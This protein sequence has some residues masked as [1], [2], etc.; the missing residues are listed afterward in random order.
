MRHGGLCANAPVRL[1]LMKEGRTGMPERPGIMFYFSDWEP[2]TKLEDAT[3]AKLFRAVLRYG[4]SGAIPEFDGVEAILWGM[5]L[6]KIDRDGKSYRARK[7]SGRYA[8]YCRETK[9]TGAEPVSRDRWKI[10]ID[11]PLSVD[12]DSNQLQPQVHSQ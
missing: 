2:L 12:N 11:Q 6:P 9:R 3:L 5:I 8:V 10:E 1:M 4:Q 7:E